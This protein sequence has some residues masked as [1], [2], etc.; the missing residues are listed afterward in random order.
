M[1][2]PKLSEN[3]AV[4]VDLHQQ[5][6]NSARKSLELAIQIGKLLQTQK[7]R[8]GHGQW[9]NWIR[10]KLPFTQRTANN[11]IRLHRIRDQIKL[12][13]V[14]NLSEAYGLLT[15]PAPMDRFEAERSSAQIQEALHELVATVVPFVGEL[16][17]VR[18]RETFSSEHPTFEAFLLDRTLTPEEFQAQERL[19]DALTAWTAGDSA[20]AVFKCL[21]LKQSGPEVAMRDEDV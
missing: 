9:G 17:T 18:E 15:G 14:S 5:I 1:I 19:C 20:D 7:D 11:Y 2:T 4:I 8:V 21:W 10:T 6:V 12:E 13:N 16:R 3:A